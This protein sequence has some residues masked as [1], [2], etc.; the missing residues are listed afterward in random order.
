MSAQT[1]TPARKKGIIPLHPMTFGMLLG[2]AFAALRHNPKVLFGFAVILQLAVLILAALAIGLVLFTTFSRLETVSTASPDFEAIAAGTIA[3]NIIAGILVGLASVA[4]TAIMQGVIAADVSY[5]TI[6]KKAT[7]R[8]LWRRM[9]PAFWRLV[10]YSALVVVAVFGLI[11][12]VALILFGIIAGGIAGGMGASPETV[13]LIVLVV[14]VFFLACIPLY[15]WL[16]TKL[17]LVPSILV[18]ERAR[19]KDA[20]VRSWRLIRGRFWVAFGVSFLISF[21]MGIAMNVVAVPAQLFA[22]MFGTVLVPTGDPEPSAIIGMILLLLAPQ[23][24]TLVLQAITLVVQSTSAALIYLDSRMRYEGLDQT[25]VSYVERSDMGWTEEQLGDPYA[26][27][28]AR[29]VSSAPPP[30]AVPDYVLLSQS[31]AYPAPTGAPQQPGYPGPYGYA[32]Q[33]PGQ[34]SSPPQ[35]PQ[36]GYAPAPQ[37]YGAPPTPPVYTAPPA[38][39]AYSAPPAPATPPAAAPPAPAPPAAAPW[40]APGDGDPRA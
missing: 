38:P 39:P 24:L 30:K 22:Q 35:P 14:V 29:A 4:V 40:T 16:S 25:L 26:V 33:P 13:G 31:Y 20:I 32:Q 19:L 23:I 28:P 36:Y 1:W 15:V 11:I 21:I 8:M 12:V 7:L 34:P 37:A 3:I 9:T 17:M 10:A 18:F 5:A 27:D 6:G 2:K